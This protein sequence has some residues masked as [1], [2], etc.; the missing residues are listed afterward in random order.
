MDKLMVVMIVA[1]GTVCLLTN[2]LVLCI[3]LR[4]RVGRITFRYQVILGQ[5]TAG[6]VSSTVMFYPLKLVSVSLSKGSVP[7][8]TDHGFTASF[9][10]CLFICSAPLVSVATLLMAHA[11]ILNI[12]QVVRQI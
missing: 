2:L 6:L 3:I 1:A 7:D 10:S 8:A 4:Q 5:C 9:V 11:L 12:E